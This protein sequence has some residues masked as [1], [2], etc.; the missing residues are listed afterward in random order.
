MGRRVLRRH[1][2][3]YSVCLFPIKG[4]PGLYE[5]RQIM[6]ISVINTQMVKMKYWP[7]Y[8]HSCLRFRTFQTNKLAFYKLLQRIRQKF[9]K[10]SSDS[11]STFSTTLEFL[12]LLVSTDP[13][14]ED[15]PL[16]RTMTLTNFELREVVSWQQHTFDHPLLFLKK[17]L[18]ESTHEDDSLESLVESVQS[19]LSILKD[20]GKKDKA[21]AGTKNGR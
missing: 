19:L 2:W 3:G 15:M 16:T 1:I 20:P 11:L 5:L 4:T 7:V 21:D 6:I 18:E 8:T 14:D 13:A 9:S 17:V 10:D 12:R